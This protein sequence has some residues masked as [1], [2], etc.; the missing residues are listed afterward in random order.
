M[1][2]RVNITVLLSIF[3][4]LVSCGERIYINEIRATVL[5]VE[6]GNTILLSTGLRV[7]LIGVKN[8][9]SSQKY[10]EKFVKGKTVSLEVNIED[11]QFIRT[12]DTEIYAYVNVSRLAINGD[13]VKKRFTSLDFKHLVDSADVFKEYARP[14]IKRTLSPEEL[15][16]LY[17]PATFSIS[18]ESGIGSGFFINND[19]LAI[20]NAHVLSSE[21]DLSQVRIYLWDSEGNTNEHRFRRVSRI[22][23]EK[24]VGDLGQDDWVVF[25]VQ[26]EQNEQFAFFDLHKEKVR[27]GQ[28]IAVLGTP[29]GQ[30]GNFT[31]GHI[32]NIDNNLITISA[33]VNGGNSGGPVVI[34]TGEVIG[35][36]SWAGFIDRSKLN[37]AFSIIPVREA[38][39]QMGDLYYGGK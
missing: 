36:A 18:T 11:D 20:S 2:I 1:G 12:Y 7:T 25:N 15:F 29:A 19:G 14:G 17:A 4:S 24:Y 22:L 32:N 21:N 16:V 6:S 23:K 39:N 26:K 28:P 27:Q 37:W 13:M 8:T 33:D 31:Q 5:S 3:L 35:I 9:P 30:T 38:L 10:L 34:M